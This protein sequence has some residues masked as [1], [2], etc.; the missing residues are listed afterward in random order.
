M[1]TD[2]RVTRCNGTI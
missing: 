1:V 2:F